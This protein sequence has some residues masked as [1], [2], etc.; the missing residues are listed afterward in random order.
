MSSV[1][2]SRRSLRPPLVLAPEGVLAVRQFQQ[3]RTIAAFAAISVLFT[4]ATVAG[5]LTHCS[6]AALI[7]VYGLIFIGV[8]SAPLQRVLYIDVWVRLT[9]GIIVGFAILLVGGAAMADIRGFWQPIPVAVAVGFAALCLHVAAVVR[10]W[11]VLRRPRSGRGVRPRFLAT[12]AEFC[13]VALSVVGTGLWLIP[14]LTQRD[15]SP[16]QWG[17][18]KVMGP[19]WYAGL[20]LVIVALVIGRRHGRCAALA[21]FSFAL[22]SVLT[23]AL[24]YGGPSENTAAKQIQLTA[25]ILTHHHI[26]PTSGIYPAYSALFSG[27]AWVSDLLGIRGLAGSYSFLQLAT[28]WPV[29]IVLMRVIEIRTLMGRIIRTPGRRW[30][31]VMLVLLT[32]TLIYYYYSP[33]SVG[34]VIGFAALALAVKG[35]GQRLMTTG[36]IL[37]L[38]TL[39]GLSLGPSHE[40]SPFIAAGA[41]FILA[42]FGQAPWWSFL[43]VLLPAAAWAGLVHN[44]VSSSFNFSSLFSLENFRP[45]SLPAAPGH[46]RLPVVGYQSHALL[47]ALLILIAWGA[48]GFLSHVRRRAVWGYALCPAVGLALIAINPY[49]NEGIFRAALFAIPW[50]ALMAMQMPPPGRRLR[51]LRRPGVLSLAIV[52]VMLILTAT[53]PVA[54]YAIDGVIVL[55]KSDLEL[56][57]YLTDRTPGKDAYALPIEPTYEDAGNAQ[58][59]P[60]NGLASTI[61]FHSM[62]WSY[63]AVHPAITTNRPTVASVPAL[64]KEYRQVAAAESY[65]EH[66]GPL[67]PLYIVWSQSMLEYSNAYGVESPNTLLGWLHALLASRAVTLVGRWDQSYLFK[68]RAQTVPGASTTG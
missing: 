1:H 13:S 5:G 61:P 25:Y 30:I 55:R 26:D 56:A 33:Q 41:L 59:S 34:Y 29:L 4:V 48:I 18:L 68:V 8:G 15:P 67:G 20:V 58:Y 21:V 31:G 39:A 9:G 49:G 65:A 36:W 60:A 46:V 37:A 44:A 14:A 10:V 32:D 54:E 57:N 66:R 40:L 42:V 19:S 50:I 43:P 53:F 23:P 2:I 11:P 6:G 51:F 28:F 27:V 63:V 16:T 35:F 52:V 45:P 7:G 24:V 38:L 22:A 12:R 3:A 17:L 62:P 47:V 64:V